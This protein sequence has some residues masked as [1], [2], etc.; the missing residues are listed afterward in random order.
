MPRKLNQMHTAIKILINHG[1]VFNSTNRQLKNGTL[2][3]YDPQDIQIH[4]NIYTE[5]QITKSGYVRKFA[6]SNY[7]NTL[8][9]Y[10]LNKTRKTFYHFRS[11]PTSS[12]H[13]IKLPNQYTTLAYDIIRVSTKARLRSKYNH[14]PSNILFCARNRI[15]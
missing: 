12:T 4:P 3:F 2:H 8:I 10:Q 1:L 7:Y 5:Y 9:G 13:R 15:H 11:N 6:K 14:I